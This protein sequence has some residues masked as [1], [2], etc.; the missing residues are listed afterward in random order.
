[1][2]ETS[3]RATLIYR[4]FNEAA[5]GLRPETRAGDFGK[6]YTA[7]KAEPLD[8]GG[9]PTTPRGDGYFDDCVGEFE[10]PA[11]AGPSNPSPTD[12]KQLYKLPDG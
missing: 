9:D 10:Y 12:P 7:K 4:K 8:F 11:A 2:A 3:L 1:V 6:C 5:P